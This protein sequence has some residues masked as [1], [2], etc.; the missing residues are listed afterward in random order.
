[1][2]RPSLVRLRRARSATSVTLAALFLGC[3]DSPPLSPDDGGAT[4]NAAA[5]RVKGKITFGRSTDIYVMSP[6]G[7]GEIRLTTSGGEE[8]PTLSPSGRQIAF[9]SQR[10]GN[11]EIYTMNADG[12][13]GTAVPPRST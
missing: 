8:A 9:V 4:V 1:M 6:D 3:Q 11:A 13:G 10:D 5:A 2:L 12:T 7:T